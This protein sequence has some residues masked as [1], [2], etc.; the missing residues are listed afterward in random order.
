MKK[1]L[2]TYTFNPKSSTRQSGMKSNFAFTKV[3]DDD[4]NHSSLGPP[5]S[6][7]T[8]SKNGKLPALK[9]KKE[10]KTK[11]PKPKAP[12]PPA[13][14]KPKLAK[15]QPINKEVITESA[16]PTARLLW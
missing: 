14:R 7:N 8:G 5:R 15:S 1:K 2:N 9:R 16:D 12:K 3:C 4:S 10:I 6:T 11:D 13:V